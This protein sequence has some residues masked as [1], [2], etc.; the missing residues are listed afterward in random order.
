M[1][2]GRLEAFSD[3]VLA[4]I[5]TVMVL[6]MKVP[7]GSDINS[8]KPVFP[9]FLSYILSFVNI[10]IYWNNHHHMMIAA[11]QINGKVLWA[12]MHLIFWLSLFPFTS[13]WMGENNFTKLP[14]AVYGIVLMMAGIAYYILSQSLI[15]LHGKDSIIAKAVGKD[16]K[17]IISVVIYIIAV[18][19]AFLNSW[20]SITMYASVA[21][22]WFIPDRRIEKV[23]VNEIKE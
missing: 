12:N 8:L 17:G 4:I 16:F 1:G 10:G 19:L 9:V 13:G 22:M 5:I 21:A 11:K 23:V 3:G 6:E 7:R 18:P 15:K 2:K 14:V 20:I